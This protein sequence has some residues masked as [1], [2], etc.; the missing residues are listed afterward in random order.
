MN[1]IV[2][3]ASIKT[4]STRLYPLPL[5]NYSFFLRTTF[6]SLALPAYNA[7][8]EGQW[9]ATWKGQGHLCIL[10]ASSNLVSVRSIPLKETSLCVMGAHRTA[11]RLRIIF[12]RAPLIRILAP[13]LH[14][15]GCDDNEA[16]ARTLEQIFRKLKFIASERR[17]AHFYE[18]LV[19][20]HDEAGGLFDV[21]ALHTEKSRVARSLSFLS[22]GQ[23]RLYHRRPALPVPH[24]DS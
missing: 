2:A 6:P 1:G 7:E 18:H 16:A 9:Q 11:H 8:L 10:L 12:Y 20:G 21:L 13:P 17:A 15:R 23:L 14:H 5:N 22:S 24:I 3:L 19:A 4:S